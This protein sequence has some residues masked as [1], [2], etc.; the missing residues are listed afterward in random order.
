[1][2]RGLTMGWPGK[3]LLYRDA[4][5]LNINIFK[6]IRAPVERRSDDNEDGCA[7]SEHVG[8]NKP[9][10]QERKHAQ[11]RDNLTRQFLQEFAL[12]IRT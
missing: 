6:F 4:Q 8:M 10:N 7:D 5:H 9:T 11:N 3:E 1:M 12:K 2:L